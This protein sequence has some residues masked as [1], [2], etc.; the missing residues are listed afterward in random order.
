MIQT[1]LENHLF[2]IRN[3]HLSCL[4]LS[5]CH[6][7]SN[8]G[9]FAAVILAWT[10]AQVMIYIS[11]PR[12]KKHRVYAVRISFFYGFIVNVCS[13]YVCFYFSASHSETTLVFLSNSIANMVSWFFYLDSIDEPDEYSAFIAI[14]SDEET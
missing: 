13:F 3:L 12:W 6:L 4:S 1:L 9:D 14:V 7:I 10:V 11:T 5:L 2:A 8:D